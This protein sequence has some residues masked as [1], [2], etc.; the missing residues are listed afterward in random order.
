M[1][2]LQDQNLEIEGEGKST[3]TNSVGEITLEQ[4]QNA[5]TNNL[6]IKGY[7]D[8]VVDKT[9]SKRL[10]KS[11]ESWKTNNLE[12]LINEE[13][14]KRY[15]QKSEAEIKLEEMNK[16]LEKSNEEKRQLELKMQYQELLV[17]SNIPVE[18]V[19]YLAGKDVEETMNNIEA[20]KGLMVQYV[21][22]EVE[23]RMK[24]GSYIPG[25]G[26]SISGRKEISDFERIVKG[27]R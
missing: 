7:Y 12:N 26:S 11:I 25:G 16:A 22:G 24:L 6:D 20:F 14:D 1:E 2:N 4:F 27:V 15:P 17:K 21:N 13:I 5:I 19:K 10:D 3:E 9:V 8:S 18:M 23:N